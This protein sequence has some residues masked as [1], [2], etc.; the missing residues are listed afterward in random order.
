MGI[1]INDLPPYVRERIAAQQLKELRERNGGRDYASAEE[2][3]QKA[4]KHSRAARSNAQ[5][6]HFEGEITKACKWYAAAGRA[7]I[8]KTPESFRVTKLHD[9][10]RF[11][12]RFLGKAQPD[13]Q[14]T[15]SGGRSIIF[16]AKF[17]EKDR[18]NA[19]AL[20]NH[21]AELLEMHHKL[22]ALC[23][24]CVGFKTGAYFIPWKV[25]RDMK[26]IYGRKYILRTEMG[27]YRAD[28]N[29]HSTVLF[30]DYV[31]II[32]DMAVRAKVE[33]EA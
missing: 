33:E 32:E 27:N 20:T 13:F 15:L 23:G 7:V 5:G 24:V 28:M 4:E 17:T 26:A 18:I 12:G 10:G 22:G 29:I 31:K 25:W 14:G 16:D 8:E 30:L 9:G 19:N 11:S 3:M 6:H 21:Q 2:M 1:D